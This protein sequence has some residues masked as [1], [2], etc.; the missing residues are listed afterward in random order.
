MKIWL[1]I[2]IFLLSLFTLAI[3]FVFKKMHWPYSS[4]M[5]TAGVIGILLAALMIIIRL[6]YEDKSKRN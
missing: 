4:V 3:G 2:T 5:I 1:I 6:V